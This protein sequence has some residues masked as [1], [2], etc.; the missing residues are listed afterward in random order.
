MARCS[1]VQII[2]KRTDKKPRKNSILNDGKCL[3]MKIS[4]NSWGREHFKK[5]KNEKYPPPP[6]NLEKKEEEK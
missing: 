1:E 5:K 3:K 6:I 4:N 2:W